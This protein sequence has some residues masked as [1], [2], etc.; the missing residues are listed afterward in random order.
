MRTYIAIVV[1]L[2]STLVAMGQQMTHEET[3]ALTAGNITP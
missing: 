1:M 2:V 3:I